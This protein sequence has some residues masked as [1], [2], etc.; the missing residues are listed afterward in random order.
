MGERLAQET[1]SLTS[2]FFHLSLPLTPSFSP[3]SYL[4]LHACFLFFLSHSS[5][6]HPPF[7]PYPI[8]SSRLPRPISLFSLSTSLRFLSCSL[9]LLSPPP[10]IIP[11]LSFIPRLPHPQRLP[12]ILFYFFLKVIA[13]Q[14]ITKFTICTRN[15]WYEEL[16]IWL[17]QPMVVGWPAHTST[18]LVLK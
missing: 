11:P 8:P 5:S 6:F 16:R 7:I 9:R 1:L 15:C 12:L 17:S 10:Y 3:P 18:V 4:I 13:N 2:H 14:F